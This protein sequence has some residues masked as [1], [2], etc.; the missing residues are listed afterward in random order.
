[1]KHFLFIYAEDLE[2]I[3]DPSFGC[4]RD[5]FHVEKRSFSTG[6]TDWEVEEA[7]R[8]SEVENRKGGD[9]TASEHYFT[10]RLLRIVQIA[11]ELPIQ[12]S[13]IPQ[14]ESRFEPD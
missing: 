13:S 4:Y 2:Y 14:M 7:A 1:M 10:R 9:I 8:A 12:P 6:T 5:R 11:R 3:V